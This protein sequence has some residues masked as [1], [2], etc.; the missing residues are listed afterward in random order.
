VIVEFSGPV[1]E[2]RGPAPYHFLSVPPDE[3]DDIAAIAGDITYGWGMVPVRGWLGDT[4]FTTALWPK[5]GG[6]VV[7]LKDKVRAAEGVE[8]GMTVAVR[9]A[10]AED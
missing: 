7:P 2:W 1:W 5:D 8:L 4:E 6:Y 3:A 9:L 10:I